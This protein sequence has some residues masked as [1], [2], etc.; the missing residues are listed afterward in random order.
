MYHVRDGERHKN[1]SEKVKGRDHLGDTV[2][3]N[4]IMNLK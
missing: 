2:V 4:S 3:D 1:E